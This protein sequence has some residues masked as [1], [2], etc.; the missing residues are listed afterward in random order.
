MIKFSKSRFELQQACLGKYW[1]K[2]VSATPT[3]ETVWPAT[4][5]GEAVHLYLEN[6]LNAF[7]AAPNDWQ[8]VKSKLHRW[9]LER[10]Q[11]QYNLVDIK[12]LFL[13]SFQDYKKDLVSKDATG[14]RVFKR[15]RG[16][17]DE[18]FFSKYPKW[19]WEIVKFVFKSIE[20]IEGVASEKEFEIEVPVLGETVLVRGVIDLVDSNGIAD[21]KT[22]KDSSHYYFI[23]WKSDPQSLVY[24]FAFSYLYRRAPTSFAYLVF[25]EVERTIIVNKVAYPKD[26]T[27]YTQAFQKLLETFVLNHRVSGDSTRWKP[28]KT[29]CFFCAHK[30]FC[31]IAIL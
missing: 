27:E 1:W 16:W 31:K 3:E 4:L 10:L 23:D 22:V 17:K 2:Y 15:N 25:N 30:N 9:N 29:N 26:V 18:E 5:I 6:L 13:N 21:F 20:S 28:E 7:I 11:Q 12:Q 24:L 14:T 19:L 8:E